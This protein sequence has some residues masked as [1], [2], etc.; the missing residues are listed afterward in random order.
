MDP[1]RFEQIFINLLT[2]AVKFTPLGGKVEFLVAN[3]CY[4]GNLLSCDFIV[5]D[6]GIGMSEEFQTH[7]FEAFVQEENEVQTQSQGT[8]L[9]LTIVKNLVSLMN[10]TISVKS[11]KGV[12]T[13][14]TVHLDMPVVTACETPEDAPPPEISL[15]GLKVLLVEDHPLNTQIAKKLLEKQ[16]AAVD[17]AAN[18]KEGARMFEASKSG[19]YCAILMDIRMP[20]MNGLEAAQVIR[21][22]P[23]ADA[24]TVPIISMTANAFEEDVKA[25]LAAGMNEHLSKPIEPQKLYSVLAKWVFG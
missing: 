15:K 17:C 16:G 4:H 11:A 22:M 1:I 19:E 6:N 10:G 13:E 12:G 18:G 20:V 3:N 2:N 23:R 8:G 9:G 7:M 24:A 14:F 5:R 21:K 25:T